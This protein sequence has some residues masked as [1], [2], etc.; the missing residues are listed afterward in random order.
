MIQG[1]K[2]SVASWAANK[3]P[4]LVAPSN[5]MLHPLVWDRHRILDLRTRKDPVSSR[6][7]ILPGFKDV[8]VAGGSFDSLQVASRFFEKQFL[9]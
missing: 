3:L 1:K 8:A 4:T 5:R 9:T 6:A 2:W 7:A